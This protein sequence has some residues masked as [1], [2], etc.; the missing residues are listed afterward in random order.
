MSNKKKSLRRLVTLGVSLALIAAALFFAGPKEAIASLRE[1]SATT[2]AIIFVLFAVNLWLVSYRLHQVLE[3]FNLKIP[4][5]RAW[6]ASLAGQ[7]AGQV[8]ISLF[9]QVVG[10]HM[11]LRRNGIS[12]VLIASLTGYERAIQLIVS[13]LVCV[14]GSAFFMDGMFA[15][16]FAVKA[17]LPEI[18]LAI[19]IAFFVGMY[20]W[21]S[22]FENNLLTSISS[23]KSLK[24]SLCIAAISLAAQLLVLTTFVVGASFYLPSATFVE[25]CSAAAIISFAASLPITVNGWGLR[26]IAAIYIFGQLGMSAADA[27]AVSLLVGICSTAIVFVLAPTAMKLRADGTRVELEPQSAM[28]QDTSKIDIEKSAA[29]LLGTSACVLIFFQLY[30]KLPGGTINLNLADPFALLAIASMAVH[31]ASAKH[32]PEWEMQSFNR[33]LIGI[34][35]FLILGFIHGVAEIGVTQWALAGRLI[36]WLV[37]LGY[38]S[39]GWMMLAYAGLHGMRRMAVSMSSTGAVIVFLQVLLRWLDQNGFIF[40]PTLAPGFDGYASN[41]NAFAFQLIA[42][43]I[44]MLAYSPLYASKRGL[45]VYIVLH[46]FILA[47]IAFTASRAGLIVETLLLLVALGFRL[48]DRRQTATALVVACAI[49]ITPQI[50]LPDMPG[51]LAAKQSERVQVQGAFSSDSSNVERIQSLK[52][53]LSL[54]Q[55]SPL[56]G[57]GL[58]V[59]IEKSTDGGTKAPLVIHCTPLWILAEFGL[60]GLAGMTLTLVAFAG[61]LRSSKLKKLRQRSLLL[62]LLAFCVF[63][64]VHEIFYQRVFWLVLG[65]LLASCNALMRPNRKQISD[66]SKDPRLVSAGVSA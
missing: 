24:R 51:W 61:H 16:R 42:C 23:G 39:L 28:T 30:V 8:F 45:N 53:G 34:S 5:Y 64:L 14:A 60:A 66:D 21:R 31:I 6:Q 62:I 18:A 12:P 54:W 57:A 49:W 3:H 63:G 58:G 36:G 19:L 44:L 50:P 38:L 1:F 17:S 25:L 37:L 41:R 15:T 65:G 33:I 22:R 32:L 27:T 11:V 29:W 4:F 47:G 48:A 40:I 20:V 26:E 2:V 9:G 56:L 55:E 7:L 52:Q 43:S 13:A 46:A 10:R 35:V 59:A